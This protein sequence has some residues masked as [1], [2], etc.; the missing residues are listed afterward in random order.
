[1]SISGIEVQ[2]HIGHGALV[3]FVRMCSSLHHLSA[4]ST[5]RASVKL[6]EGFHPI[7]EVQAPGRGQLA[8]LVDARESTTRISRTST[9]A[10]R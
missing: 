4:S 10:G 5:P 8:E 6:R 2:S 3:V 7:S 9:S 1:M